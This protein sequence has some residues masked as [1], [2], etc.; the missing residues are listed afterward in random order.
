MRYAIAVAMLLAGLGWNGESAAQ[1]F[2]DVVVPIEVAPGGK[3]TVDLKCPPGY[4]P[5][6]PTLPNPNPEDIE[7]ELFPIDSDE[8]PYNLTDTTPPPPN[9]GG[10]L[11]VRVTNRD[12]FTHRGKLTLRCVRPADDAPLVKVRATQ[13][14]A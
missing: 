2:V 6:Y 7:I 12:I 10:G 11:I 5:P 3:V 9:P 13:T 1:E 8:Q 4:E 14:I